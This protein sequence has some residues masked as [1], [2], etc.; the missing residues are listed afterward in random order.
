MPST[1][2]VHES[3]L[4][5]PQLTRDPIVI[6]SDAWREWLCAPGTTSFRFEGE[7]T[8]FTARREL[9][10]SHTYWYA[11]RRRGR[12]LEKAYLGRSDAID[13]DRLR[14][15]A[16]R[17]SGTSLPGRLQRTPRARLSRGIAGVMR[18]LLGDLGKHIPILT[19]LVVD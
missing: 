10:S 4:K 12:R 15:A 2:W 9:R 8:A 1:P 11:Y 19:S 14:D 17:L 13:L 3:R 7:G 18:T 6:G 16:V 5:F